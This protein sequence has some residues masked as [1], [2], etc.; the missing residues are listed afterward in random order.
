MRST[1]LLLKVFRRR[2]GI[3]LFIEFVLVFLIAAADIRSNRP[4]QALE[5]FG[6]AFLIAFVLSMFISF[7]S[8]LSSWPF[9]VSTRQRAWLPMLAFGLIWTVGCLAILFAILYCGIGPSGTVQLI[10]S[11]IARVPFYVLGFLFISR[12]WRARPHFMSFG[13]FMVIAANQTNA[14]WYQTLASTYA[15]WWPAVLG[16]IAFYIYEA[17]I[18][19]ARQDRQCSG[20]GNNPIASRMGDLTVTCRRDAVTWIADTVEGAMFLC[21]IIGFLLSLLPL[22]NPNSFQKLLSLPL[23][24]MVFPLVFVFWLVIAFKSQYQC[25]AASGFGPVSAFW[26]SLMQMTIV[27]IPLAQTLG[28]KKGV[29]AQCDQCRTEKFLWALR[30]PHCGHV[31]AGTIANKRLARLAKGKSPLRHGRMR[32]LVGAFIPFQIFLMFGVFGATGGRPFVTHTVYLTLH[33][34]QGQQSQDAAVARIQALFEDKAY[35][36]DWLDACAEIDQLDPHPPERFRLTVTQRASGF[37]WVH[38]SSLRWD[39]ADALPG[40]LGQ[41][42]AEEVADICTVKV[43][44]GRTSDERS[45]L[46]QTRSY[47]DN[48]IHWKEPRDKARKSRPSGNGIKP[49]P[50]RTTG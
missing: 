36:E 46:L 37:I 10:L 28:A 50:L 41:R 26:V 33:D 20:P 3:C 49:P 2:I 44:E 34:N 42:L 32:L 19:L 24:S 9:P 25:A 14:A 4:E 27:L 18:Q 22:W 1:Y 43:N 21:L 31:G 39:P 48:Q 23:L 5:V 11:M 17:P 15:L 6:I 40:L 7:R 38:S 12:I 30:C 47:L 13:V 45:P 29:V 8:R 35:L 16:A